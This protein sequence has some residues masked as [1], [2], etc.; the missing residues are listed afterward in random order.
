MTSDQPLKINAASGLSWRRSL[1]IGLLIGLGIFAFIGLVFL[2]APLSREGSTYERSPTGYFNW[3]TSLKQQNI[4]IQRWQKNYSKLTGKGQTLIQIHGESTDPLD[5]K[6]EDAINNW[7]AKGNTLISLDWEGRLTAAPFSSR[8]NSPVGPVLIETIRRQKVLGKGNIALLGDKYGSVVWSNS[9]SAWQYITVAYPWLGAN[10]YP[11][12]SNNSKFLTRL[13]QRQGGQ[14][15]VDEW[16]H[17][18]RDPLTPQEQAD[19]PYQDPLEYLLN[20]PVFT[21]TVQAFLILLLLI[22]AGNR[23]FGQILVTKKPDLAN[24][25]RYIQ[26]L[27]GVLNNARHS[28]FVLQH[29]GEQLRQQL[30]TKLGIAADLA[31]G[32][33]RLDDQ[34]LAQAWANQSGR[35][36]QELLSLLQQTHSKRRF[37]DRE[38]LD[39]INRAGLI[40]QAL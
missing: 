22:W 32:T 4:P 36:P 27:A 14:I 13:A 19:L 2:S 5:S 30:A 17:G 6:A 29:L 25:E 35:S 11:S 28:D 18:Y 38:L 15:W 23:R 20:T 12:N 40:L 39:W 3:Y 8:L 24:S 34:Q 37:S 16:M 31:A 10:A 33:V 26:S 1:W 9:E 7:I 21:L